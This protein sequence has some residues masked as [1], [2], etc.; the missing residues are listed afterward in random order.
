MVYK[1]PKGES[2]IL[3]FLCLVLPLSILT[4][5]QNTVWQ[6]PLSFWSQAA[7]V[8]PDSTA[9]LNGLGILQMHNGEYDQAIDF[10]LRSIKANPYFPNSYINLAIAYENKGEKQTALEYYRKFIEMDPQNYRF[11]T[12]LIREHLKKRY[13]VIF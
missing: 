13:G 8:S 7:K 12:M 4:W 9:A 11:K 5:R 1:T 3:V 2:F 10:F 6:S